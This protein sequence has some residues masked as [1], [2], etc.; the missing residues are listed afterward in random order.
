MPYIILTVLLLLLALLPSLWV[1][2]VLKRHAVQR[3]DLAGTGGELAAHLLK[4]FDLEN[5][6]VEETKEGADHYDTV[7]KAVRLSPS[8]F[9]G[10]SITAVAVATH[11]VGH[12]IQFGREEVISK[13]RTKYLPVASLFKKAG[14]LMVYALPFAGIL[15]RSPTAIF[16]FIALSVVLQLIGALLYLI[17]LPEEWDASFGKALPILTQGEYVEE[18]DLPAVRSVLK[19]AAFTYFARALGDLVNVGR[20]WLILR[21]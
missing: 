8:I 17:V 4:R 21:R 16:L 6:K 2:I 7:D 1:R 20:W 15:L 9:N 14:V 19:A 12:A 10:K 11:E 13:L 3:D 18:K 5:V